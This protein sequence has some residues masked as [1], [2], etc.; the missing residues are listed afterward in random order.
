MLNTSIVKTKRYGKYFSDSGITFVLFITVWK[1]KLSGVK[2]PI[3]IAFAL[4]EWEAG[5]MSRQGQF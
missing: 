5:V 2:L 3:I 4:Q 1:G